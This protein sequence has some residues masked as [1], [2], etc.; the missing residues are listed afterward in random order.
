MKKAND[1][2]PRHFEYYKKQNKNWTVEQ[3][4]QAAINFR[5]STNWQNIEYYKKQH[6]ELSDVECE[7]LRL[8]AISNKKRNNMLNIEYWEFNYSDKTPEEIKEMHH[9]YVKGKNFQCIEYYKDKFPGHTETEYENMLA[10]A[11]KS[12]LAKRPD[13][14][15]ENNPAY[16]TKTTEH[17]RRVRSPRCIEFYE[18]KFPGKTHDEYA[19]MLKNHTEYNNFQIKNAIKT[20]NIEYYLNQ[21][22]TEEEAHEALRERQTTFTYDKCVAKYGEIEGKK[23][24]FTRQH[25]WSSALINNFAT[26]GGNGNFQ[27]TLSNNIIKEINEKMHITLGQELCLYDKIHKCSYFYDAC[28]KNILI[29]INGDYWHCNPVK[30]KSTFINKSK[31]KTAAELWEH[32]NNKN[33]CAENAGYKC[34]TIWEYDYHNDH[35]N[36]INKCIEFLNENT[37]Q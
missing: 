11:K 9:N 34:Y 16:H 26:K 14:S 3:C 23:R 1:E 28:Y 13:N 12:Y 27:S 36:I 10:E 6:P 5:K 35:D 7:Q 25:N 8:D 32:D 31:H 18:N 2:S 30:Y 33:L 37:I 4:E 15:S 20:N 19:Q 29:E 24:Y 17:E 22:M 21:G